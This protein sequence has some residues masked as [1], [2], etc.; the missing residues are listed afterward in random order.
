MNIGS[1]IIFKLVTLK[2]SDL[3]LKEQTN[4]VLDVLGKDLGV[5]VTKQKKLSLNNK[6]YSKGLKPSMIACAL[7]YI[8]HKNARDM[9][10]TLGNCTSKHLIK[11]VKVIKRLLNG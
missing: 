8:G 9:F 5:D 1:S 11:D 10:P 2:G 4:L 6:L 3:S 7:V